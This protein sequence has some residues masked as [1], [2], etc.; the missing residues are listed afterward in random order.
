MELLFQLV[1]VDPEGSRHAR[2]R[3]SFAEAV[4]VAGGGA[5]GR[6]LVSRLAGERAL[7]VGKAEGPVRLI[8]ITEEG[9]SVNLIHETLIR[10]KGLDA[11]GKPQPYWQTLWDYIEK[12]KERAAWSE[13]IEVDTRTWLEKGKN[14]ELPV[15][16]R[17]GAGGGRG[18]E[19]G[20]PRGRA[21][22]RGTGVSRAHRSGRDAGGA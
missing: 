11:A 13:R 5:S 14:A 22:R 9:R 4:A 19:A 7:D 17:T 15:V 10:S 6:A 3:L 2:R 21:E 12:H 16:A 8:T 18:A 1:R 20:R